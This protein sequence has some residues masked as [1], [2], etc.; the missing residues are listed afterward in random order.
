M[1]SWPYTHDVNA[2]DIKLLTSDESNKSIMSSSTNSDN[3]E[4]SPKDFV[5]K[6]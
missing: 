4:D 2:F 3:N 1:K 6:L 5:Y